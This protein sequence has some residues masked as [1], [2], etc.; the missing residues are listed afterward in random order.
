MASG[1]VLTYT[2]SGIFNFAHGAVAFATA[3]LYYQLNTGLGRP[4]RAVA[5]SSRA[6]I[7]APLLGSAPRPH[8][9]APARDGAGV[10]AHRRDHRAARRAASLCSGWS[11]RSATTCSDLGFRATTRSPRAFRCQASVRHRST[12]TSIRG[13]RP[14]LGPDR[15]VRRRRV[16][17]DRALVRDPA[18][19][20]RPRDARRRRPRIA[21][22]SPRRQRRPDVG[23]RVDAHDGPRRSRWRADRAAVPAAGLVFT[24]VVLGSLAAVVLGGLRSI[25]IAFVG[26]PALGV[27]QN[28]VAGYSDDIL[29]RFLADL[30]RASKSAVP[31]MLVHRAALDLRHAI[32]ARQRRVGGGRRP[33]PDHRDRACRS[34]RR[35][36][37]WALWTLVLVAFSLQWFAVVVAA[38]RHLRPDRHRPGP[39]DGGH[40]PLVR[41]GHR[42]G[43][44]GEPRRRRAS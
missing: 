32:G 22:Q 2:T 4:D 15:G 26:R 25:P 23:G 21:R 13:R 12:P 30:S 3:Y 11:W 16:A 39:G 1:L 40:L 43:R 38:G 5:R 7:F 28:L 44:H 14:Q 8:P 35:R 18:H 34:W 24:L 17:A 29:P 31:F 10:R 20:R 6:F 42:H 9:A 41:R 33:P 19:P 37:P 36:L 27:V